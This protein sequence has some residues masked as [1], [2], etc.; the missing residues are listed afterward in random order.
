[1]RLVLV[2]DN[3]KLA[4]ALAEGLAEE[5]Y[6][7]QVIDTAEAAIDVAV[8]G[9]LDVMVLDLGLPDRDGLEVLAELRIRRISLPVLVLTA[10]DSASART[11]AL[12]LGAAN[13]L[14]KPFAFTDLIAKLAALGPDTR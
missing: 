2:E 1:M 13:Y 5:G 9:D 12:D 3:L 4:S 7:V 11:A 10:R 8:R 14:V 6:T